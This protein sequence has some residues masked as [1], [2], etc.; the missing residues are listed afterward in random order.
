[1]SR[2]NVAR[3]VQRFYQDIWNAHDRAA[4]PALLTDDFRFRG[5]LGRE[6]TGIEAFAEYVDA[7][8]EALGEYRCEIDEL[9]SQGERAFARMTFSG[10][11]RAPLLGNPPTGKRVS[12]AGAALFH[13]RGEKLESL[14]V[15]G[16]LD[17]LR[18]QLRSTQP[19]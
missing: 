12:W 6:C 17:S 13:A 19:V 7:V 14:W 2:S 16:D 18:E 3:L 8:H 11:H 5:S 15:L 4:L 1:M 9:V 10:L